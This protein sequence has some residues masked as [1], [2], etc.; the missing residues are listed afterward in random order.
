MIS[1]VAISSPA[2]DTK[3]APQ[4]EASAEA[5]PA[6]N[7]PIYVSAPKEVSD[8][9]I[10][11]RLTQIFETSGWF[12]EMQVEVKEGLVL[13]KGK[14][15]SEK[16]KNWALKIIERTE[17]V[18]GVIDQLAD[19]REKTIL[20]PTE[21]EVDNMVNGSKR[22]IPYILSAVVILFIFSALAY[23]TRKATSNILEKKRTN[24]I[25][26]E[27]ISNLIGLVV[28][29][30]GL[31]FALKATG[32]SALSVT[33]LGSTGFIGIGIGLALKSTFENYMA[34]LM[35]SMREIFRHGEWVKV[36][37][38][39]GIVH[40]VNTRGT[41]LIN[42]EGT[43]ITIPNSKV[44]SSTIK[45]MSRNPKM[46]ASFVVGIGYDQSISK[47]REIIL[48]TLKKISPG[49]LSDPEPYVLVSLLDNSSIN[50]KVYLWFDVTQIS[51][52]RIVSRAIE[53]SLNALIANN[54][55]IP[56]SSREIVFANPLKVETLS[57][58]LSAQPKEEP[59]M[60]KN[61]SEPHDLTTEI[62][63]IRDQ[64]ERAI[65]QEKG[66]DVLKS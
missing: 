1:I 35:I 30:L 10:Q 19:S 56:D 50:L 46:R 62:H 29:I 55:S 4:V 49:I 33:V 16:R 53:D 40:T 66:R 60:Q 65:P 27:A 15:S 13:L 43:T 63:E 37:N 18:I 26:I 45:N 17:G 48:E 38:D 5:N 2:K 22:A 64:A 24:T 7:L 61:S 14:V 42:F 28:I 59:K 12:K 39:E 34:S 23:Y 36:D 6:K 3:S 41:T 20:T 54:I 57:Q 25:L 8:E 31:Y 9:A 58:P 47:A 51:L 52:A 11:K 21:E 32:L 44:I